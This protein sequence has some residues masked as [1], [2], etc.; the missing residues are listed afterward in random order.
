MG[1][2]GLSGSS[3]RTATGEAPEAAVWWI[4]TSPTGWP[5][6]TPSGGDAASTTGGEG[7]RWA[8]PGCPR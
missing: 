1:G 4:T 6:E 5:G 8:A 3:G 7:P 2:S